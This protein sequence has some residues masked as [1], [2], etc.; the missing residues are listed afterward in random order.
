MTK[1]RMEENKKIN[2]KFEEITGKIDGYLTNVKYL[3][4]DKEA[5][6]REKAALQSR[7]DELEKGKNG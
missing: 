1:E 5:N 2:E 7:I 6:M 3:L 4:F